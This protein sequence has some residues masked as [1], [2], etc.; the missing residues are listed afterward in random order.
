M[1]KTNFF[2]KYYAKLVSSYPVGVLVIIFCF[3]IFSAFNL[4]NFKLDASSDSLV[5][6]NDDDLRYYREVNSDYASSDFLI[7]LF[8]PD[9]E[10][11][12]KETISV[13]RSLSDSLEAIEGVSSVLSYLDAP[14]LFSPKMSMTELADDL[15]TIED[16]SIDLLLAK[17]EFKSSALYSELLSSKDAR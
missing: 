8:N 3:L 11:F 12:S 16:D 10:L 6:E 15:K 17:E 5:L 13:V 7:V 1:N 4:S 9:Q 2:S 14:L